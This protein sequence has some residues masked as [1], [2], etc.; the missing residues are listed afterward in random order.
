[1]SNLDNG[2]SGHK[3]EEDPNSM[4]SESVWFVHKERLV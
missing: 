2:C 4:Q 1:M 3:E